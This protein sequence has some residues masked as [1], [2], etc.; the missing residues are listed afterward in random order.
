MQVLEFDEPAALLSN[1]HSHF[2][3]MIAAAANIEQGRKSSL[4]VT[5]TKVAR[6]SRFHTSP[7]HSKNGGFD[8]FSFL[9]DVDHGVQSTSF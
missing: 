6:P 1:P 9:P 5:G 2:S 3:K 4:F 8:N 7:D